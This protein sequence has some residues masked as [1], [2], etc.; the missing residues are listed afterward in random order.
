MPRIPRG[1]IGGQAYHVLNRG[2]GG[3]T[4]FHKDGD[5]AAFLELLAAAKKKFHVSVFGVCL[6]PNHFH[7]VVQPETEATLSPFMHWWMT[8]HVRRYHQHYRSHG[9]VWQGR[10]KRFPIQQ[11]GHLLTA[12]RYVLRNPVRA[13]LVEQAMDWPWSSLRC[14][15]VSDPVPVELPPRVDTVD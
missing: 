13:G 2:N 12:L 11:D 6:M 1:L 15:S 9:H 4:V 5:Y 14:P 8:S 7:L 10:F 3:A